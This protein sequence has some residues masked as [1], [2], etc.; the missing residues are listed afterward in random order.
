MKAL[1]KFFFQFIVVVLAVS[2]IGGLCYS[3]NVTTAYTRITL[4]GGQSVSGNIQMSDS[5]TQ[6]A[7]S[8]VQ[9]GTR[10]QVTS[11]KDQSEVNGV[12]NWKRY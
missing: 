2:G 11:V 5:M 7:G 10:F 3:A 1:G 8:N 4:G 9:T 12:A 6:S